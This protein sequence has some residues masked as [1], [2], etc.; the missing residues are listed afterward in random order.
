MITLDRR[1]FM[2]TTGLATAGLAALSGCGRGSAAPETGR[3]VR[4]GFSW[5][6]NDLRRK[7]FQQVIDDYQAQHPDVGI[8]GESSDFDPYWDRLA[9]RLAAGDEPDVISMDY[10]YFREYA[11]RGALLDLSAHGAEIDQFP[12]SLLDTGRVDGTLLGLAHGLSAMALLINPVIFDAAGVEVPDDK[13]GWSW[14]DLFALSRE[15]KQR[16]KRLDSGLGGR[17]FL[18]AGG[19]TVFLAQRSKTPFTPGPRSASPRP[20]SRTGGR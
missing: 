1:S 6:G 11:E 3:S 20:I 15:L 19:F 2:I 9:T 10:A 13:A 16:G 4:L 12:A 7:T 18:Q 14:D 17:I 5:W 8:V